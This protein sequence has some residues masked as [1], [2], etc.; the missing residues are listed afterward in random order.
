MRS[1]SA[2]GTP[3]ACVYG[4]LVAFDCG[5]PMLTRI[6]ADANYPIHQFPIAS[7]FTALQPVHQFF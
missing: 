2:C 1:T 3:V 6:D 4:T 5:T 7:F